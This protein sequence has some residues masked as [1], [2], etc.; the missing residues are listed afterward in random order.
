MM[1]SRRIIWAGYVARMGEERNV[2]T[3]LM[4]NP[5]GKSLLGKPRH[6]WED[7]IKTYLR[8]LKRGDV[9]WIGLAKDRN[10][11]RA[12]VNAVLNFCVP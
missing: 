9:E 7:N 4:G 5:E 11:W 1:K 3:L 12:L 8:E 6:M 2:Y 10:R